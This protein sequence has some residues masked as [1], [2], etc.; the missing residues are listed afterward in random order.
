MQTRHCVFRGCSD[1]M[2]S[3]REEGGICQRRKK[4]VCLPMA[5]IEA[6]DQTQIRNMSNHTGCSLGRPGWRQVIPYMCTQTRLQ[7]KCT[8][9]C[10]VENALTCSILL[11]SINAQFHFFNVGLLLTTVEGYLH[12]LKSKL[13][14]NP[15]P[16]RDNNQCLAK[17]ETPNDVSVWTGVKC[18]KWQ[19]TSG[20]TFPQSVNGQKVPERAQAFSLP[21]Q[22]YC[23]QH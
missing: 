5:T 11:G 3:L 8:L 15:R 23:F 1:M 22:V 18:K 12:V 10:L 20:T 19:L 17:S 6:V 13:A 7:F 9:Y 16:D 4:T 2:S 14:L 21:L